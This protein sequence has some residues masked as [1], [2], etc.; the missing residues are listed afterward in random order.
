MQLVR[1]H[2]ATV[3]TLIDRGANIETKS[4]DGRTALM[5]VASEG[6]QA[7]AGVLI[8]KG[9]DIEAKDKEGRTALMFGN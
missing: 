2:E 1:G 7:L 8:D 6:H 3:S 5:Y 4:T 9:A